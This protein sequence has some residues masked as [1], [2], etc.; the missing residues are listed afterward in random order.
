LY[1]QDCHREQSIR[2]GCAQFANSTQKLFQDILLNHISP[3]YRKKTV[4]YAQSSSELNIYPNPSNGKFAIDF[5]V[6]KDED[7]STKI[8]NVFGQL[9]YVSTKNADEGQYHEDINLSGLTPGIYLI[10]LKAGN[11]ISVQ[12]MEIE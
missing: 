3:P 4:E 5:A 1:F 6:S 2:G 7:V 12:R 10:E 11:Q 9:V 8:F